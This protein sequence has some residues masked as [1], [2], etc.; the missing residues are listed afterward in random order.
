MIPGL[1]KS[2]DHVYTTYLPKNMHLFVYLSLELDPT[3][4][5]VNVHPTK[6]E[7]HF[8]NEEKIVDSVTKALETKLLGS[9]NSRRFFTQSK[10]PTELVGNLKGSETKSKE[11]HFYDKE[12][13]RT[14]STE[15]KLEKFFGA[16]IKR[17][18]GQN[19]DNNWDEQNE[20]ENR[21]K[22]QDEC[23]NLAK[24]R[25]DL[26]KRRDESLNHKQKNNKE[27]SEEYIDVDDESL[28]NEIINKPDKKNSKVNETLNEEEIERYNQQFMEKNYEFEALLDKSVIDETVYNLESS[29]SNA[30]FDPKNNR[31]N[32]INSGQTEKEFDVATSDLNKELNLL[33]KD[34]FDKFES[35]KDKLDEEKVDK[36]NFNQDKF[37]P[38]NKEKLNNKTDQDR[39]ETLITF[40]K[41]TD[42]NN[43]QADKLAKAEAKAMKSI[44]S[45]I[46][47]ADTNL[48]SVLTL[49]KEAEERCHMTMRQLFSQHV[50]VGCVDPTRALIQSGTKL[51]LCK[52]YRIV[53]E[54]FYQFLL[55]NF[56][57]FSLVK[58]SDELSVYD[59]ALEALD[60]PEAGWTEG[61]GEKTE[62][63][64][65]ISEIL[66]EKGEML[67][68]YFGV[69]IDDKGYISSLPL[70]LGKCQ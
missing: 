9:N 55:Y 2:I 28:L 69:D 41:D 48:T 22:K 45:K 18:F 3:T 10:L 65:R 43:S 70:L 17:K 40:A 61:D 53:E 46:T 32:P 54:L 52:T 67:K 42:L 21:S 56:E 64:R 14:D 31:L 49:R 15:Q 60:L 39:L 1:K 36:P 5:D 57:N 59:L 62:L 37:D 27:K 7:V 12:L 4:I 68:E 33:E 44:V 19:E 51:Y 29:N 58:F 38:L 24:C 11:K 35:Y 34:K 16:P 23:R 6:H 66:V 47:Q 50:F 8:M 63:A 20:N 13:V 30:Q 25:V 26:D